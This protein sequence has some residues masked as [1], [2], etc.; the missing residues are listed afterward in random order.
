MGVMGFI[1]SGFRMVWHFYGVLLDTSP[2]AYTPTLAYMG[3]IVALI[4]ALFLGLVAFVFWLAGLGDKKGKAHEG[5]YG[6]AISGG[7][8]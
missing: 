8:H 5:G 1:R 3:R 7:D 4:V 2:W 6:D